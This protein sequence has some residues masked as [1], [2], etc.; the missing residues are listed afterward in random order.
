MLGVS[1]SCKI[2]LF[3]L[4]NTTELTSIWLTRRDSVNTLFWQWFKGGGDDGGG[5]DGG[6][7]G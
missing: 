3:Y 7:G 6:G 2:Y 4:R 1:L 5:G